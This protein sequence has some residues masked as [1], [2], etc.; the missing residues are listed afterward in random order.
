[1]LIQKTTSLS[2][3]DLQVQGTAG[4]FSGYASVFDGTDTDGDTIQKGAFTETLLKSTPRMFYNHDWD[5]PVGKWIKLEQ[6]NYGLRVTGE[7]TPGLARAADVKAAM[8][9]NTLGG[10]SIGGFL[11]KG[12][13]EAS[14]G[15]RTIKRW[16]ELVEVSLVVFPADGAAL[17]DSPARKSA[18]FSE[19]LTAEID[20]IETIREFETFL[21]DAGGLSKGVA[22]SLAARA[23]HVFDRRDAGDDGE[24]NKWAEIAA[25]VQRLAGSQA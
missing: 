5:M 4:T 17:L 19:M 24:A 14:E 7:F 8:S 10:L 11:R 13:Y 16:S 6:D 22:K 1:M 20:A 12:D 15:K 23:K 25:R 18:M 3:V 21:R 2:N 9:H